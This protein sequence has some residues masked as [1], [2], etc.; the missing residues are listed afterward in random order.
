M[1]Y[2]KIFS[3]LVVGGALVS[4]STASAHAS[5]WSWFDTV[6]KSASSATVQQSQ[7]VI[8]PIPL[9]PVLQQ[10][11]SISLKNFAD[12]AIS[13]VFTSGTQQLVAEGTHLKQ[14]QVLTAE[15]A[16]V[17]EKPSV[18]FDPWWV[19]PPAWWTTGP[20]INTNVEVDVINENQTVV[21]PIKQKTS[22][23]SWWGKC[24]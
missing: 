6:S 14:A 11:A 21:T 8:A 13:E 20:V 22:C 4:M 12:D 19:S 18:D 5:S 2:I 17:S 15:S 24:F 9:D 7:E 16:A 1:N 10:Q 3:S 23:P